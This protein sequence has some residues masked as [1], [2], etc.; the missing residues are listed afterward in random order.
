MGKNKQQLI[1]Q[2][3]ADSKR[4]LDILENQDNQAEAYTKLTSI[5]ED[6]LNYKA[7][8]SEREEQEWHGLRLVEN[9]YRRSKRLMDLG[10]P[11]IIQKNELEWLVTMINYVHN[12][13]NGIKPLM[14]KEREEELI[15]MIKQEKE[16]EGL[17]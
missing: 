1:E 17:L 16:M 5:Y 12:A 6:C 11:L 4:I 14:P 2:M 9:R 10:A 13:L 8:S 3:V 7:L 15:E